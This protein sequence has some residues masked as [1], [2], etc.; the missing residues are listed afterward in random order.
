MKSMKNVKLIALLVIICLV[1]FGSNC[2]F[3]EGVMEEENEKER[4][5][6]KV[7]H[8]GSLIVPF[9]EIEDAFEKEHP[10]VDVLLEGHGSIQAIRHITDLEEEYDVVAVAD[11]SLIPALMYPK[12][13]DWYVRFARN[14]VVIAYSN[15]SKYAQEINQTNWYQILARPDVRFGFSNP[16]FDA[17][18]YRTLTLIPLAE[19]YYGNDTIFQDLVARNFDPQ[20]QLIKSSGCT[21]EDSC[22]LTVVVPEIFRPRSEKLAVRGSSVQ[23][24]AMLEY[25]AL[26]YIFEYKSVAK[27]HGLRYL[28]LPPEIDLSNPELSHIYEKATVLLGF[29]R[30][31]TVGIK[32]EGKPI[33]YGI[34]VP[35]SAPHPDLGQEF[36]QFV[37]SEKGREVL[38]AAHQPTIWP[39]VEGRERAPEEVKAIAGDLG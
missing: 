22:N 20:L 10:G 35:K 34:T 24:I 32:R 39:L 11:E 2:I 26:D 6:L 17:C 13:A 14:Q 31:K 29:Q 5:E 23:L 28:E 30:F 9:G 4:V 33:F 36:V 27:Q 15:Q 18:G 25:A 38:D 21:D 3:D 8:A 7:I 37:I 16:M 12:Y 19:Q 1:V